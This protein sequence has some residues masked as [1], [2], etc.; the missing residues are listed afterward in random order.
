MEELAT[1]QYDNYAG[2]YIDRQEMASYMRREGRPAITD[3]L[4]DEPWIKPTLQE[5]FYSP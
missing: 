2:Q 4:L 5:A 1:K 3:S